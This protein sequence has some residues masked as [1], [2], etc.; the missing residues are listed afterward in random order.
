MSLVADI[1]GN[2]SSGGIVG[3]VGGVATGVLNYFKTKQEHSFRI[4][5]MKLSATIDAAKTAGDIALAR[6]AGAA[7]AFTS[8]QQADAAI[9]TTSL[10]VANMRGF[11]RPGLTWLFVLALFS[12]ILTSVFLPDWLSEAPPLVDFG[13]TMVIDTTGMMIAWWF[14]SRQIEKHMTRWGNSTASASVS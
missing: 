14:G 10:W 8:S 1:L 13:V 3:L 6:E 7:S 2:V 9:G 4:E 5:E 11:T 12:I